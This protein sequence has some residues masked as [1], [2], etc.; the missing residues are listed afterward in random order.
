[1]QALLPALHP[2]FGMQSLELSTAVKR[3]CVAAVLS[4]HRATVVVVVLE[5]IGRGW[6][7]TAD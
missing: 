4:D 2:T 6:G 7:V 3:L 5:Y 1:M